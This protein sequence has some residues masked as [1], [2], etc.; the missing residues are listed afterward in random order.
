M[1]YMLF[2]NRFVLP[3]IALLLGM[4]L[5]GMFPHTPLHAVATDRTESFL[6]ATGLVDEGV[7]GIYLLDCLT[8]D[9]RAA[10]L[11]KTGV[12]FTATY[13][14]PG[15]QLMKDFNLDASKNPKFLMVTGMADL[16]SGRQST[17][18]AAVV[19][20]VELSSGMIRA[21][22]IPWD[23]TRFV[24]RSPISATFM[25]VGALPFRN[26]PP[27]GPAPKVGGAKA[28]NDKAKDN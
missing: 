10:V 24:A 21:Y 17:F 28:S 4:C 3:A 18:G 13:S 16:R 14:Y 12:G 19:Y 8:G 20:V 9:L 1:R 11:G 15:A 27:A 22:A 5:G 23:R 6:I 25:P 26:P 2:R 7:E